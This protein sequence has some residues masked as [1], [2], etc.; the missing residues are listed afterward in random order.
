MG[1]INFGVEENIIEESAFNFLLNLFLINTLKV[2]QFCS[3]YSTFSRTKVFRFELKVWPNITFTKSRRPRNQACLKN[4]KLSA[5]LLLLRKVLA[6]LAFRF[7]F[8]KNRRTLI[9]GGP[10]CTKISEIKSLI[11][12]MKLAEWQR[13]CS[14]AGYEAIVRVGYRQK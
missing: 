13:Q 8:Q 3:A 6:V 9:F 4:Y 11:F 14:N 12:L 2:K 5:S 1:R 7:I 10:I